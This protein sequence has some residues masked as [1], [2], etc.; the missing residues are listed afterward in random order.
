MNKVTL[1]AA[2]EEI[3]TQKGHVYVKFSNYYTATVRCLS[4]FARLLNDE[5]EL[6]NEL[7]I[8]ENSD[9]DV[10]DSFIKAVKQLISQFNGEP[11][12]DPKDVKKIKVV[13]QNDKDYYKNSDDNQ[14]HTYSV[15]IQINGIDLDRARTIFEML[16]EYIAN[17][18]KVIV[19]YCTPLWCPT[20]QHGDYVDQNE[21]YD[22]FT[23]PSTYYT[24]KEFM[25]DFRR[26]L[27]NFKKTI[28]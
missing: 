7:Q 9:W 24:K 26:C 4:D 16:A 12:I 25:K 14:L 15:G 11:K 19:D 20:E 8:I 17:E 27:R 22:S 21:F 5:S 1:T 28:K 13:A 6:K 3:P 2:Q 23:I 18:D 10:S